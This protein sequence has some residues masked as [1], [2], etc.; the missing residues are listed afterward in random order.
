MI[1]MTKLTDYGFILL[2][3][4]AYTEAG[5]MYNARDLSGATSLPRP[6]V[7]KI[8]KTLARGGILTSHR[9]VKG[10]YSLARMA[11]KIQ[12]ADIISA[13]E[14][15]IAIAE[16]IGEGGDS[17]CTMERLCPVRVN[18]RRINQAVREALERIT[19][20]EMTQP[21]HQFGLGGERAP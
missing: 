12:V 13:L 15:P 20:D 5:G 8:L 6:M 9:G 14:G 16:C 17:R 10:G 19:L 3:Y 18:W 1:R 4:M 7:S 11:D 21:L 2:T